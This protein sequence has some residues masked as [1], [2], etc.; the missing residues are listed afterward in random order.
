MEWVVSVTP[1]PRFSPWERTPFFGTHCT[2]GWVGPR[3]GLG[4]EAREIILCPCRGS[5]LDRPI[6]QP[7]CQTLY[8]LCYPADI[9]IRVDDSIKPIMNNDI[10]W[11]KNWRSPSDVKGYC[12]V[13]RTAIATLLVDVTVGR[14]LI[15]L[16]ATATFRLPAGSASLTAMS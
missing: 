15:K 9:S 3:A 1:R 12:L 2:G 5:N 10:F 16:K 11:K 14:S 8:W 6:V 4:T 7:H 13:T